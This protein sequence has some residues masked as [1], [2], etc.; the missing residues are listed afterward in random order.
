MSDKNKPNRDTITNRVYPARSRPSRY[1]NNSG[2]PA[3][4]MTVACVCG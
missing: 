1:T 2:K 3:L 4:P